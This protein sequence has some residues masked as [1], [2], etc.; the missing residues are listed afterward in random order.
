[1]TQIQDPRRARAHCLQKFDVGGMHANPAVLPLKGFLRGMEQTAVCGA[2]AFVAGWVVR[3]TVLGHSKPEIPACNCN[4]YWKAGSADHNWTP[5]FHLLAGL[6]VLGLCLVFS[7]TAL[8][9]KLTFSDAKTGED[10][11]LSLDVKGSGKS[12]G[13]FGVAKG[14]QIR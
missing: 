8:A 5:S 14:V 6:V 7:Q 10:R 12:K 1:M 13:V 11:V 4:C 9:L 3:D 2:I